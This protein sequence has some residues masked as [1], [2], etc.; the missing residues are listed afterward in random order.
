MARSDRTCRVDR[1]RERVSDRT[2][3]IGKGQRD[4]AALIRRFGFVPYSI[5]KLSRGP[6]HRSIYHYSNE[7]ADLNV[8]SVS[9]SAPGPDVRT[10]A[11]LSVVPAEWVDF[12]VRYYTVPG[13]VYLDP[14]AGQGVRAQVAVLRG[15]HYYGSDLCEPF[16]RYTQAVL[17]RLEVDPALHVEVRCADSSD[18]SWVPDGIGDFC[19]TSP[20]YWDV[21]HYDD[22]PRQIGDRPYQQFL[23]GM[24]QIAAAWRPKFKPGARVVV[25]V[26]DIR[27]D[28]ALI[29]Y[30]ADTITVMQRAGYTLVDLAIIDGS[31]TRMSKVFAVAHNMRRT[32]PKVHEYGLV[33]TA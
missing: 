11:K 2:A 28:G 29:P 17:E 1:R 24:E 21:E 19:F 3:T 10:A 8:A 6:L 9:A 22:D 16:V 4:R 33:F 20:P 7:R 12:F 25:N 13:D 23:D 31:T 14:F 15:L 32:L 27:R 5:V 18:P 26:N 30:H